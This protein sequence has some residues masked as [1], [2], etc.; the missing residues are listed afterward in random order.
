LK[1]PVLNKDRVLGI[2]PGLATTGWGVVEKNGSQLTLH[3]FGAILTPAR[4]ELSQR[5][6]QI[7]QALLQVIEQYQPSVLAI[8]E[9]YFAKFAVSI[10]ATAQARG[11]ILLSAAEA[12]LAVVEYNP[13]T[14]KMAMTGFGSASKI[15]M[16]TMV[17]RYFRLQELPQPDDAADAMAIAL[18]H[19]QTRR[20]LLTA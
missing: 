6:R 5:L 19:L 3:S 8:E 14:V 4:V 20:E 9:L 17:Q 1:T 2:D 16:Q 12:G 10:A 13:R 7:R 18:C 15:Q 11:A